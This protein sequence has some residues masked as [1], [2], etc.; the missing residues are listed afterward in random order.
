MRKAFFAAWLTMP[1]V[2]LATQWTRLQ[3]AYVRSSIQSRIDRILEKQKAVLKE[4]ESC[5]GQKHCHQE[6][7]SCHDDAHRAVLDAAWAVVEADYNEAAKELFGGVNPDPGLDSLDQAGLKAALARLPR[8]TAELFAML[9]LSRAK[10]DGARNQGVEEVKRLRRLG[11]LLPVASIHYDARREINAELSS[12]LYANAFSAREQGATSD[13]WKAEAR[14]AEAVLRDMIDDA[15]E[16]ADVGAIAVQRNLE[17]V[18]NLIRIS[19]SSFDGL[20]F[21]SRSP[22]TED[23]LAQLKKY[24]RWLDQQQQALARAANA[25][26][27]HSN[28]KKVR[29]EIQKQKEAAAKKATEG[30]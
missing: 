10:K 29:D 17:R 13:E 11:L 25:K 20:P 8:R 18:V 26:P 16:Q 1:L 22:R 5:V 30:S 6:A 3:D 19:T 24:R 27:A 23:C 12:T 9:E 15:R 14:A 4:R 28:E 7:G 2:F 21:P